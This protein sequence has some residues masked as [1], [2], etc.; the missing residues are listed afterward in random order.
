MTPLLKT[1]QCLSASFRRIAKVPFYHL[2]SLYDVTSSPTS[3]HLTHFTPAVSTFLLFFDTSKRTIA[4]RALRLLFSPCGIL[5]SRY[6]HNKP[7]HLFKVFT[8]ISF[9]SKAFL[10]PPSLTFYIKILPLYP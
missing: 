5:S 2:Q 8:Q 3:L 6:W 4:S 10:T 1:L 7:P 9:H